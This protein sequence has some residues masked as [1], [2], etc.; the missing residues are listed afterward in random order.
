MYT[1][2]ITVYYSILQYSNLFFIEIGY[3]PNHVPSFWEVQSFDM[4]NGLSPP[5]WVRPS[6]LELLVQDRWCPTTKCST[7]DP[8]DQKKLEKPLEFLGGTSWWPENHFDIFWPIVHNCSMKHLIN[9]P[10][11]EPCV[12]FVSFDQKQIERTTAKTPHFRSQ[13]LLSFSPRLVAPSSVTVSK[14]RCRRS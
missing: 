1:A 3:H 12:T 10:W 4:V 13:T 5:L 7:W 2:Y 14:I 8:A 11:L 9:Q 6:C